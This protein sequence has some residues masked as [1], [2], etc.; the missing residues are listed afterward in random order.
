MGGGKGRGRGDLGDLFE[1]R[2]ALGCFGGLIAYRHVIR[3]LSVGRRVEDCK[4]S[5]AG[6]RCW[7]HT[8]LP[9]GARPNTLLQSMVIAT[10]LNH[11]TGYYK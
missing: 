9:L 3:E 2:C 1:R 8:P 7:T 6:S 11:F 10:Y 5:T 4:L